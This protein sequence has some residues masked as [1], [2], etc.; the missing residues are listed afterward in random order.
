MTLGKLP[1]ALN[2]DFLRREQGYEQGPPRGAAGQTHWADPRGTGLGA[3]C[4]FNRGQ[5]LRSAVTACK[6]WP[7]QSC[8]TVNQLRALAE[9]SKTPPILASAQA[10]DG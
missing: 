2:L 3:Q 10:C 4:M 6:P 9:T 5:L 1:D 7:L 8:V